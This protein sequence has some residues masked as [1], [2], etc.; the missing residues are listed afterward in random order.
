MADTNILW[1]TPL[2]MADTNILWLTPLPEFS[3]DA[4]GR[5]KQVTLGNGAASAYGYDW[6]D[7]L[8]IITHNTSETNQMLRMDYSR[9]AVGNILERALETSLHGGTNVYMYDDLYQLIDVEYSAASDFDDETITYDAM[10]N[11][12]SVSSVLSMVEYSPNEMNQ[13]T[14]VGGL[15]Y[16]HDANGNLTSN[17]TLTC[18]YDDGNH[19]LSVVTTNSETTYTY[20]PRAP[21]ASATVVI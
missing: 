8:T 5:R 11:R 6:G 15:G 7:R 12:L 2:R 17:A 4:L 19:L 10:G 21:E 16:G 13:Y 1:L 14:N 9:D 18:T 20:D 3:Y